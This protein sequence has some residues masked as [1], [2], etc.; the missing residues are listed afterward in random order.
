[1]S[2][3]ED[4]VRGYVN[5]DGTPYGLPCGYS[6]RGVPTCEARGAHFCEPRAARVAL[7]LQLTPEQQAA[8]YH[9]L[10]DDGE[11]VPPVEELADSHIRELE[12]IL[13]VESGSIFTQRTDPDEPPPDPSDLSSWREVTAAE[14]RAR[15]QGD[16][17]PPTGELD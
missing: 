11:P 4:R 15:A 1:M 17:W 5:R 9:L 2:D 14:R 12:A 6:W 13:Q 3:F 7:F 10:F 16:P 8:D